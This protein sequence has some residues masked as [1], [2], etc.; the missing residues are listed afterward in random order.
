M[1]HAQLLGPP[2]FFIF[3]I[4]VFFQSDSAKRHA[5]SSVCAYMIPAQQRNVPA[6]GDARGSHAALPRAQR[7]TRL[8]RC[9]ARSARGGARRYDL[10]RA[11]QMAQQLRDKPRITKLTAYC[12]MF[13][14]RRATR[15]MTATRETKR[16]RQRDMPRRREIYDVRK[17]H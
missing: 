10:L 2:R 11:W 13:A 15:A 7:K 14:P 9:A 5:P 8:R 4:D 16:R 3:D 6:K 12:A 17:Q 1:S